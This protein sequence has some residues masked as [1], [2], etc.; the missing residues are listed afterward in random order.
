[1]ALQGSGRGRRF[2][3]TAV[4]TAALVAGGVGLAV[5]GTSSAP[6]APPANSHAS[7]RGINEF[8]MTHAFFSGKT[9][10]FTYTHGFYCDTSVKSSAS[11]KCEAG[12]DYKR[13]PNK[14]FDPLYITVPLGFT[15]P[16]NMMQCPSNLACV[17]H[18][19][20]IDESRLEP[21]LKPLYPHL[22]KAQ[23]TAALKNTGVEGHDHYIT[24]TNGTHREWW[25]V[26]IVGVTS[27]AVYNQIRAHRSFHYIRH[28]I[29]TKNKNVVGPIATN[30]FLFFSVHS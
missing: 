17:D 18:P 19:G 7:G 10:G 24:T 21:A 9:Y 29:Q 3:L 8:G 13:P 20:T 27:K 26:K 15:E 28:L 11:S 5:A 14:N 22:T 2:L 4:A 25:D 6:P 16:M 23:L 12:A 1:M 30:L